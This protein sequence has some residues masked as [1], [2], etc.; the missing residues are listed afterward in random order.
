MHWNLRAA[1]CILAVSKS[2]CVKELAD[3]L[4]EQRDSSCTFEEQWQD[5]SPAGVSR[6][7]TR[8]E[9]LEGVKLPDRGLRFRFYV[10]KGWRFWFLA[11]EGL[12]LH[13]GGVEVTLWKV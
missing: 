10:L 13:S 9:A 3:L 7:F 12:R 8:F 6:E 1:F 5:G 2:T 11:L 4:Q